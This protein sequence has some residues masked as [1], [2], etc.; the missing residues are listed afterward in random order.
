MATTEITGAIEHFV[1][2]FERHEP[3]LIGARADWLRALRREALESFTRQGLPDRRREDWRFTNVA[4]IGRT[5]FAH[6]DPPGPAD[7]IDAAVERELARLDIPDLEADRLV[8]IDGHY[9]PRLSAVGPLPPGARL[10]TMA[11]AIDRHGDLA[12]GRLARHAEW[13]VHP[14]VALNTAWM[15]D[16]A[17]LALDEGV[18]LERP[19]HVIHLATGAGAAA[20]AIHPRA[21]VVAGRASQATLIESFGGAEGSVYLHNAVTEILAAEDAHLD[22]YKLQRESLEA[23]HVHTLQVRQERS[24]NLRTHAFTLG[25]AVSRCDINIVLDGEGIESTLNGLYMLAGDQHADTH[26]RLDHAR[27]H[28]HSSELYKGILDE[29]A[30]G[31]FTGRI[32]VRQDAQKTDAYQK[33]EALLLSETAT[34][35]T[36]PQ[37]EIFADDVKCSHGATIGQLDSEATFYLRSRGIGLDEARALLTRAFAGAIIERVRPAP[38]RAALER[39]VGEKFETRIPMESA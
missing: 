32:L 6:V 26:S 8:F 15:G 3:R 1:G 23:F 16:G 19:V 30:G 17:F 7:T 13:Q 28:C 29:R 39:L 37:L 20:A 36:Q 10:A 5:R 35:N 22:H 25:A 33:N 18:V 21:L 4:P 2:A 31:V 14:F 11:E 34:I 12:R 27:P 38:V 9:Q 24:S